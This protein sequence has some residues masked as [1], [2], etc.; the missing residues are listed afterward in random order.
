MLA[1]GGGSRFST[2]EDAAHKL[3][4]PWR[5]HP[6]AWWA[7]RA[8]LDAGLDRTWVVC[9][10]VDLTGALPAGAE[11]LDNPRWAD[12]Q[13]TSLQVAIA[14][15]RQG[16][17]NAVVVGLADQPAIGPEAWQRVAASPAPIAIATYDGQRRNPVKLAKE[18]WD[19][20]PSSGDQGARAVFVR[21]PD[22]GEEVPC[23]GDP[24]DIDTREDLR[25]WS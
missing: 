4:A 21:R 2:G 22:L 3:L 23:E 17:V 11:T 14:A 20:L 7:V 19:L 10:A 1:A 8:A 24:A 5:G 16:G 25:R 9:G 13:A 12:G 15:A 6:L 18:V